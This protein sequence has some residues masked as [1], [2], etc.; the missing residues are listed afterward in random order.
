MRLVVCLAMVAMITGGAV[1]LR[2][3]A[4]PVLTVRVGGTAL[5]LS[6]GGGSLWVLVCDSGCAGEARESMG[7]I[8][9]VDPR[10]GHIVA[11][12]T[13][14]R[15]NDIAVAASGVYATDFWRDTIRRLDPTTLREVSALKL[16]LPFRFTAHDNAFLPLV[17]AATPRAVWVATDRCALAH[18]NQ[19]ASRVIAT[20]RLPCAAFGGMSAADNVVWLS[21][22]LLGV[23][24][25]DPVTNRVVARIHLGPRERR[26]NADRVL[27][28]DG[29]V[30]VSG[31]WTSGGAPT[32]GSGLARIDPK[33]NRL[34]T[35]TPLPSGALALTYGDHSLWLAR[36]GGPTV[37]RI[38]PHTGKT[39]ATFHGHVGVALAVANGQLWTLSRNGTLRQLGKSS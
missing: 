36:M 10:T 14:V 17:V 22:S 3:Q 28:G 34:E 39:I 29:K 1:S 37:K 21:E 35:V 4:V 9:R 18:A 16:R 23:Y 12:A 2:Q 33:R 20:V 13:L 6:A 5:E 38:D 15:P 30:L 32:D 11:S 19:H 24:R 7:R 8:V 26:L 31:E 27:L 25:V